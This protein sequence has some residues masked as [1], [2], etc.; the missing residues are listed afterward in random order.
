MD[1]SVVDSNPIVWA[2]PDLYKQTQQLH[3]K[4]AVDLTSALN[5]YHRLTFSNRFWNVI[6]GP[7]LR[8][9]CD[10]V[11][12]RWAYLNQAINE[13]DANESFSDCDDT[14]LG[15]HPRNFLEYRDSQMGQTWNQFMY[16]KMWS[17]MTNSQPPSR[18]VNP[19]GDLNS[20][21]PDLTNNKNSVSNK[22]VFLTNTYLPRSSQAMLTILMGS[23]PTRGR[24]IAPPTTI[25][26]PGVRSQLKFPNAPASRLHVLGREIVRDQILTA[27]VEGFPALIE[28]ANQLHLPDSPRLIFTSNRH[29]Y[30]DVFNAWV[31]Q[32]IE[33]GSKY[34]IGQHGGHYGMSKF[35]S[36]SELHEENISDCYLTWGWKTSEK[37]L[38]GPC[39]TTV[40]RK[41]RPPAKAKHLLIV[42]D[43]IWKYP[44]SLFYDISEHEGYLEYVA[45]CVAGLP[46]AIRKDV[47]IRLNHAHAETGPS[48]IEWWQQHDP[49]I[50]VDPGLSSMK[51]LISD[52]RLVVTTYNG[53]TFL[54]TLNLN[55]PT[56]ITWDDSYVQLRPE[57]FTYIQRLEEAGIFHNN[58]QSFVD[59]VTK[60]WPD[61]ESW[62]ASDTV[63][64]ARLM[65][66][67]EFSRIEP[68]PLL[69]LRQ[70]LRA[71]NMAN[72]PPL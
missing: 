19:N 16:S 15:N 29:L 2:L 32:A 26:D 52:S 56:L 59:H 33:R 47:L 3:S 46:T 50:K 43:H 62:W 8:S 30:D 60:H 23:R 51:S 22:R 25:F 37:Q 69:F 34:V 1:Y 38:P 40:G 17:L 55:I 54:E 70:T 39:L 31:A 7:W 4:L 12:L 5:S 68:H 14:D 71:V 64:S 21:P 18:L 53:T 35:P 9:I 61:I 72:N 27:Y 41:Y 42:C 57:A 6:I 13:F 65:F 24:R 20:V 66:C 44:R 63:Q 67:K 45:Q 58:S 48:Q 10:N 49:T 11:I 28:S 36:F